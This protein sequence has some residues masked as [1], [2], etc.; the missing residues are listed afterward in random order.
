MRQ[1]R[2]R[3]PR[4]TFD[5][6][7][8]LR[9]PRTT[10]IP[11]AR[12]PPASPNPSIRSAPADGFLVNGSVNNGAASPFAQLAA[13]GNN[14]RGQR[15]LYN[16]GV[17]AQSRQL[18]VGR[19]PVLVHRPA[20]TE[21]RLQRRAVPR[22]LRRSAA[23]SALVR[24]RPNVFLGYQRTADHNADDAVGARA[25]AARARAAT[26]RRRSTPSGRPMQIVDP[27]TGLPFAGNVIPRDAHQPAGA[28]R[29]SA[30]TR[31]RTS[32]PAAATTTRRRSLV[33]THQDS[34]QARV[35]QTHQRP[36]SAVRQRSPISGRRPSRRTCSASRT[37]RACPALDTAINW[38]HRFSQFLSL[39]LRYQFTRAATD[40]HAVLREPHERVGR[41]R[42]HRQQP[43]RR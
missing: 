10:Q 33:A 39:R 9:A 30:T 1:R 38:S 5:L 16:G 25:D 6:D 4:R 43:G 41:R 24:N 2:P 32:T 28:R 35:T 31:R 22:H 26:S 27:A 8:T 12:R 18:G 37:R 29:S 21:A 36:Q 11:L 20:G 42:H 7:N 14:R 3:P 17:G 40:V 19:A 23:D 13:F 15:S 34:V